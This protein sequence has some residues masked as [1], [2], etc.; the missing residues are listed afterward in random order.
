MLP[1][2]EKWRFL[3]FSRKECEVV[4]MKRIFL[5]LL[6]VMPGLLQAG[7]LPCEQ[8]HSLCDSK[9]KL[10]NIGDDDAV[11]ICKAKCLGKR[12]SCSV[13]KGVET[14]REAAGKGAKAAKNAADKAKDSSSD[15]SEKAKAF[16][17][18]V[19]GD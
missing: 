8:Q 6:L 15:L 3:W 17:E 19:T 5:S 11:N 18:G 9:C 2:W 14:A 1:G 12:V 16:W 10:V 4:V 13:G 7:L